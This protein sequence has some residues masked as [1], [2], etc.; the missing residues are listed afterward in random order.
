MTSKIDPRGDFDCRTCVERLN[1]RFI[2]VETCSK[3]FF[4]VLNVAAYK[5][6]KF[7][8]ANVKNVSKNVSRPFRTIKID[9]NHKILMFGL[10]FYHKSIP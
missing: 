5:F 9:P 6:C 3:Q 8:R 10:I 2:D 4:N 1:R 7:D